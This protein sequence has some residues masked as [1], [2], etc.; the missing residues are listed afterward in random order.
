MFSIE[1]VRPRSNGETWV[2]LRDGPRPPLGATVRDQQG[3]CWKVVGFTP[4]EVKL[5]ALEPG[6]QELEGATLCLVS[7]ASQRS[8][9]AG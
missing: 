1:L 4:S 5:V 9:S 6:E 3:A 8:A 7:A 2:T